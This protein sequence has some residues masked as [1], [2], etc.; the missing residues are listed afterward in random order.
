MTAV[1]LIDAGGA[2]L[3]SVRYALE[4]L[5]VDAR[6]V[7][8]AAGLQGA[9]RVILPG[10]GAAPEAMSRLRAQGLVEPLQQL[11]VP[12]I[13]ICLGMQLLFEHSEEGDVDCLGLLPGIVRHMTP[14]LGIRVPH[15]GWNQL[16]PLRASALLAGLPERASA[17][18]V[19]GYAAPVTADTV[20]ACDHGGLFTAVVHQ[21]LRCGA[22]FHPERSADTGARILRNFLEM[23]F[24]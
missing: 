23:S 17:Y 16:L 6:V 9:Q 7:R 3:G 18:F 1:A 24:P 4:R 8:D 12:L 11:Q 2:N 20:A 10:V 15:M 21:G 14:A 19:H 22:Q 13:G 5:G